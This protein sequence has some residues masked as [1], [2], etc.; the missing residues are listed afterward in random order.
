MLEMVTPSVVR[1]S[2]SAL[3]GSGVVI[4]RTGTVLTSAH[5]VQGNEVVIVLI[6]GKE[7]LIGTVTRVDTARDLALVKLPPGV[8]HS[9]YLGTEDDVF[10]GAPV[11]SIGYPLN[12][13]GPASITEGIV[14]MYYDEPDL[15]RQII[16]TDA[17]I[18]LGNSGGPILDEMGRII[19]I[20]TSI[21]GDYPSRRTVGISF[22]V[23]IVTIKE[24]FLE[25]IPN[26]VSD[27]AT[28]KLSQAY[29]PTLY[30]TDSEPVNQD[31]NQKSARGDD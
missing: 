7:P 20:T 26:S 24:H 30:T 31:R 9:A 25:I 14:S 29:P 18:N 28:N 4:E 5:T 3:T 12:M 8:Y 22:A 15:G 19:G 6:E 16:Q 2:T 1:V 21:L 17:A 10:L 11:Y 23:S 13:A 27:S